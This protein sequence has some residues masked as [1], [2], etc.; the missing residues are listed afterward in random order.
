MIH[1]IGHRIP[2]QLRQE[3]KKVDIEEEKPIDEPV[4]PDGPQG[5]V[6]PKE[7]KE[8]NGPTGPRHPHRPPSGFKI[9]FDLLEVIDV[10]ETEEPVLKKPV[11]ACGL[12][13]VDRC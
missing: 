4:T 1:N 5:P 10:D 7:P 3:L 12:S 13:E 8:P 6:E 9:D 11:L 2:F